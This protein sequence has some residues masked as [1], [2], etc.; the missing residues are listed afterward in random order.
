[1]SVNTKDRVQPGQLLSRGTSRMLAEYGFASIEE[2]VPQRGLRVDV[3]AIGPKNE[4]WVIEC[5][6]SRA[7]FQSDTKWQGYLAWCD[8]FFWSVGPD[9][10]SELLPEDTGLIA[11]DAY[12]GEILRMG[13]VAPVAPARRKSLIHKMAYTAARRLQMMRDPEIRT[14]MD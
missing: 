6:S 4:I 9:F 13:P 12:G 10:P 5:K 8:R 2:F 1:M 3:M 11:A 7:D 14:S